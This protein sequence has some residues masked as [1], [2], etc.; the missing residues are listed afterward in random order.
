MII[1]KGVN[2]KL[3][4]LSFLMV[5][6]SVFLFASCQVQKENEEVVPGNS[7]NKIN[8]GQTSGWIGDVYDKQGAF[9]PEFDRDYYSRHNINWFH[10]AHAWVVP[11]LEADMYNVKEAINEN[12]KRSRIWL[13]VY[14][15]GNHTKWCD[16]KN[17]KGFGRNPIHPNVLKSLKEKNIEPGGDD[18]RG[19][20][21]LAAADDPKVMA[22]IK[23]TIKW[24]LDTVIKH[25]GKDALYG[26]M[27]SEEEPV[28]GVDEALGVDGVNYYAQHKEEVIEK[29]IKVHNELYDFVKANY[30][31][32]KVSP[33]FYPDWVRPGTLKMDAVIMDSYPSPGVEEKFIQKWI[34][35]YGNVP[36]DEHYIILWG[37]GDNDRQVELDR[38]RKITSG[39]MKR[40][41]K[42]LGFFFPGLA[43]YDPIHR[44]IDTEGTGTYLP[45]SLEKHKLDVR[46]LLDET[47][48]TAD[49]LKT[50][51]GFT[52]PAPVKSSEEDWTSR[53]KLIAL[54]DRIYLFRE[55]ALDEAYRMVQ[56][57]KDLQ[58]I[59]N[60]VSL[61]KAEKMLGDDFKC[62]AG[63]SKTQ[64][65]KWEK[66][67][68]DYRTIAAYFE[69]VV[70]YEKKFS[71]ICS[72][73]ARELEKNT[74]LILS[75]YPKEISSVIMPELSAVIKSL[76]GAEVG[77]AEKDFQ[78]IF[79]ILCDKKLSR[80]AILEISFQ[81]LHHVALNLSVTISAGFPG[82]QEQEFYSDFP[83]SSSAEI[84]KI[85]IYLPGVPSY[86]SL[87]SSKWA[88]T[89]NVAAFT[90]T[91]TGEVL[92]PEKILE[93][94]HIEKFEEW[95]SG[96][97]RFFIVAPWGNKASFKIEY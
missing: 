39:F 73:A 6:S 47:M 48:K 69:E 38:F 41:Y 96:R 1:K 53:E 23:K 29:L 51:E 21:W 63:I 70:P 66:L 65:G 30:P 87:V 24:Q 91:K 35:A 55:A 37:Y 44:L 86:V 61:L 76:K 57:M 26:V 78:K 12:K 72:S 77:C 89:L 60:F 80:C 58:K 7:C 82:G 25:C 56:R 9:S 92:K 54:T 31:F 14:W 18:L 45:Y 5:L 85:R 2:M 43:L 16:P 79:K 46:K 49:S 93:S 34:R 83:C 50:V 40:G 33:G 94:N 81:N 17:K 20:D 64:L 67:S 3:I 32:W 52:L 71:A 95:F 88:G 15:W 59:S 28:H 68:K 75:A 27:L 84:E 74:P 62:E 90:L 10:I 4:K 42:N 22:S 11:F 36:P 19:K 97:S 8:P 13:E